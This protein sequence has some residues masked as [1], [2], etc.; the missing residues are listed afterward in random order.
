M[1]VPIVRPQSDRQP[2]TA[3]EEKKTQE[4]RNRKALALID[5][6]TEEARALALPEN[7]IRVEITLT[8]LLWSRDEKRA[9]SLFKE[10]TA[11]LGEL[12]FATNS[13]DPDHL[14]DLQRVAQLRREMVQIAAR[15]D[16]RM[17]LS[18]L[19]ATRPESSEQRS[20][21]QRSP[22]SQLELSIASEL[23]AKD[24]EEALIIGQDSIKTGI[25]YQAFE[26]LG[27]L[28]RRDKAVAQKF[29]GA[30]LNWIRREDFNRDDGEWYVVLELLGR[31]IENNRNRSRMAAQAELL[32]FPAPILD[33]R[34][35]RELSS[36]LIRS[37]LANG[38]IQSGLNRSSPGRVSQIVQQLITLMPEAVST[39]QA[40]G[41]RK[42]IGELDL[43]T[44]SQRG[45]WAKYQEVVQT[46][47]VDAILEAAKT[48][49][50]EIVANL[51]QN[52]VWRVFN[53]G[54]EARARQIAE[55]V[56]DPGARAEMLVN[57]DRQMFNR[58]NEKQDFGTARALLSQIP[59]V[60]ERAR[61]MAQLAMSAASKGDKATAL[62]LVREAEVL[63]GDRARNYSQMGSQL[64]I[65]KAYGQMDPNR[66][67][68][69][70]ETLIARL[71]ELAAAASMLNGF[72]LNQYFKNGE[73][74][75]RSGNPLCSTIQELADCLGSI[76]LSDF[77][78]ARL[79]GGLFQLSEIRVIALLQIAQA[80]LGNDE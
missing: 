39:G 28:E 17:A 5:E 27:R 6:I 11:N 72:D 69:I 64:Q 51:I 45:A 40:A 78:R 41:L 25:D 14:A 4:E 55:G 8:D 70:I 20:S 62:A 80:A 26:L 68:A 32:D 36:I 67:A 56:A 47:S 10:A 34:S 75:I 60:D 53:E 65:A 35:A 76:G 30:M 15:H 77:E 18:F 37:L 44:E 63:V 2:A 73:F 22:E 54:D 1:L 16:P 24:P 43:L 42:R 21:R 31:W 49:P 19:R 58:A 57:L 50:P 59:S 71:N 33:D 13:Q 29:L 74:I 38:P 48:A 23:V 7:R 61:M 79:L 12:A 66:Q 52:A 46:G 9:R 3:G